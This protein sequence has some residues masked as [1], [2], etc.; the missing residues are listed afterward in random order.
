[1]NMG[2]LAVL[3]FLQQQGITSLDTLII[4]HPDLDHSA[5]TT[6]VH[7]H[8]RW[9]GF[10]TAGWQRMARCARPAGRCRPAMRRR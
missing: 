2:T 5:G 6:V 10:A 1:M 8:W 4:S 9:A 3:P 7:K